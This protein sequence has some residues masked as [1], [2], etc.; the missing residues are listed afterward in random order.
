MT[1]TDMPNLIEHVAG[2]RWIVGLRADSSLLFFSAKAAGYRRHIGPEWGG[3]FAETM[4][5]PIDDGRP[6]RVINL[7]QAKAFHEVSNR[8]VRE[9][10]QRLIDVI[11]GNDR[12]YLEIDRIGEAMAEAIE[13][14]DLSEAREN[15]LR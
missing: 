11:D 12:T 14:D 15:G 4:L 6:V 2:E 13:C 8:L 5:V 1:D 9:N 10:P 3:R 7:R